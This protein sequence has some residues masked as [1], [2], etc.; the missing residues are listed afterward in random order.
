ME[1]N[2]FTFFAQIINFFILIFVLQKLL[3]KPIITAMENREK[4]IRE[5]LQ[6]AAQQKQEAEQE[7]EHYQQIRHDLSL[8][9][10]ELLTQAK[11]EIEE[12]RQQLLQEVRDEV[13]IE[14]SQWQADLV[15]QKDTF[16]EELQ[17]RLI[18][19]LQLTVRRVLVDLAEVSLEEQIAKVFLNRLQ[20]MSESDRNN[21][22]A[23]LINTASYQRV[24][25]LTL[26]SAFELP[27]ETKNAIATT[28]ENY[29]QDN[30]LEQLN[31]TYQIQPDLIC[32]IELRGEGYKLTWSIEAYL[33]SI[34]ENLASVFSV[35]NSY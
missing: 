16:L 10:G 34:T 17:Y 11:L 4:T 7:M 3:Y 18:Q 12:T 21:L 20:N 31:L 28:I 27:Q 25:P 30:N 29:F 14:R 2:W 23:T 32:G 1:I 26:V 22:V 13:L 19:E 6:S 33:E 15:K 5:R 9:Q 35:E 24:I 8:R